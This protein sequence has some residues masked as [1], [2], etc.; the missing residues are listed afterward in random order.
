M[1]K[2][3][4][5]HALHFARTYSQRAPF[6]RLPGAM[7]P[8]KGLIAQTVR[9]L[10]AE[11]IIISPSGTTAEIA[12]QWC[13][14]KGQSFQLLYQATFKAWVLRPITDTEIDQI[15]AATKPVVDK[16]ENS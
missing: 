2:K 10:E 13:R 15:A 1:N 4:V 12:A 5:D 11:G 7:T 9:K 14:R 6:L 3:P 16:A 8:N